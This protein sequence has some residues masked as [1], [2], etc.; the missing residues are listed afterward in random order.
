[1]LRRRLRTVQV[2][3]NIKNSQLSEIQFLKRELDFITN[4]IKQDSDI[5]TTNG[6]CFIACTNPKLWN[7]ILSNKSFHVVFILLGNETYDI[8]TFQYFNAF[9]NV[10]FLFVYNAPRS[11]SLIL[12]SSHFLFLIENPKYFFTRAHWRLWKNAFDFA[13]KT[14]RCKIQKPF[15]RIPLG[16]T[17]R[18]VRELQ[19]LKIIDASSKKSIISQALSPSSKSIDFEISFF[20]QLGNW[21]RRSLVNQFSVVHDMFVFTYK[22]WGHAPN[23]DKLLDTPSY[24][25]ILFKS[26]FVLCPP[27]NITNETFRYMESLILGCIPVTPDATIQDHHFGN[28][29]SRDL[30]RFWRYSTHN[31]LFRYLRKRTLKQ[32]DAIHFSEI[33]KI[34]SD[35]NSIRKKIKDLATE[36]QTP[37]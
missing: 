16:Y 12:L 24:A 11:N 36:S 5:K 1:V 9:D 31:M 27:G 7:A 28:Y 3:L 14:R 6:L 10:K 8:P 4:T 30:P 18:F 13:L 2:I 17:N 26:R 33:S 35:L 34:Q 22:D 21:F 15:M 20:G 37:S 29:F 23:S 25:G 32:L 19:Q